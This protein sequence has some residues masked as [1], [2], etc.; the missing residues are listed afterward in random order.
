LSS[1]QDQAAP[2][3]ARFK[4]LYRAPWPLWFFWVQLVWYDAEQQ[5]PQ[6]QQKQQ[7]PGGE[8]SGKSILSTFS[9]FLMRIIVVVWKYLESGTF[10]LS[11]YARKSIAGR[12]ATIHF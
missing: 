11:D 12:V 10:F 3:H 2:V 7:S 6:Q 9:D 5:Q 1:E 8:A 4:P